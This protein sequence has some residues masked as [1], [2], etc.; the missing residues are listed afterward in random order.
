MWERGESVSGFRSNWQCMEMCSVA[1]WQLHSK[2]D[3]SLHEQQQ[4]KHL[5]LHMLMQH[6]K[7]CTADAPKPSC[8]EIPTC[9]A[10]KLDRW[11][12]AHV[13]WVLVSWVNAHPSSDHNP[14]PPAQQRDKHAIKVITMFPVCSALP[15]LSDGA[16][17]HNVKHV[18]AQQLPTYLQM[19]Q[20]NTGKMSS[21]HLESARR[22]IINS[23]HNYRV[24]KWMHFCIV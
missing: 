5:S 24:Q 2:G 15:S 9:I 13:T 1:E 16:Q 14:V 17:P 23:S 12:Q 18:F 20:Q 3:F 6:C 8:R 19:V 22:S 21:Y 4:F 11:L 7:Q 10:A